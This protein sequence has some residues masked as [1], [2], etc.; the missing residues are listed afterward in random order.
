MGPGDDGNK[1]GAILRLELNEKYVSQKR[2]HF[3]TLRETPEPAS[4]FGLD[5]LQ[6]FKSFF[7]CKLSFAFLR[8]GN[9][10]LLLTG[11]DHEPVI[12]I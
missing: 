7:S 9:Y 4:W 12:N 5:A 2:P 8:Q 3:L 11:R 6:R 1:M 10:S